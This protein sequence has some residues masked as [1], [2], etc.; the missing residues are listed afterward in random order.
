[1]NGRTMRGGRAVSA[2]RCA[3]AVTAVLAVA[4]CGS[5]PV[6][7]GADTR[8]H[9]KPGK[10]HSTK[11]ADGGSP[12]DAGAASGGSGGSTV[13]V[14]AYFAASTPQG[15]RLF[16]E[17]QRVDAADPLGEA[18]A[19]LVTG[20]SLDPDYSTA[21]PSGSFADVTWSEGAGAFIVT[22]PDDSWTT[23]PRDM[24]RTGAKLA[25]QQLVYT[26]Q[27][28]QQRRDPVIVQLG[29]DPVPLF[30]IDTSRGLREDPST[31][32]LVNVTSPEQGATVSGDTLQ[33]AGVANSFEANVVWEIRSGGDKVL[34]GYA[35][36]DGWMDKLYPW[37]KSIDISS[38]EPGDYTFVART[39]DPSDG[40]GAGPT[41][42]TKTFTVG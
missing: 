25:V 4:A 40:E 30:G 36:A 42:D 6:E 17:F 35:T 3:L 16:R 21:F 8:Q 32:A 13:T 41:E 5:D 10:H 23:R 37:E 24:S 14:P 20:D 12:T 38:L 11:G 1:M 31:L 7:T 33:A 39:D 18:A 27:G 26:L 19:L 29:N 9:H 34:D 22:L 15:G 2:L 28:V